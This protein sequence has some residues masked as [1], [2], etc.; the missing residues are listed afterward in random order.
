MKA[1]IYD[2]T[3]NLA[4]VWAAW[5]TLLRL[6]GWVVCPSSSWD[7]AIAQLVVRCEVV[8]GLQVWSH[9]RPGEPLIGGQGIYA[10]TNV[11]L[12]L[13]L[14]DIVSADGYVWLR[15]CRCFA[16]EDGVRLAR[17]LWGLLGC[18]IYGHVKTIGLRQPG[19][20]VIDADGLHAAGDCWAWEVEP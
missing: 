8:D 11:H 10:A 18:R 9:G 5:S 15:C 16:G 7:D 12:L 19:R 1:I 14:R 2:K 3:A 6:R 20:L 13:L 17:R 4:P